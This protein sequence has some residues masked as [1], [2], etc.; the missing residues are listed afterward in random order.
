MNNALLFR[1]VVSVFFC[2]AGAVALG[3]SSGEAD[4]PPAD[5]SSSPLSGCEKGKIESDLVEGLELSGPGVDPQTKQV[6]AGS[7]VMAST[8]LAMRPGLD[9][10]EALGVAGPVVEAV[11]TAKGAV[12]VM[13]S[14]SADCAALRTLSV[15]ESEEDMFAFVMGPAHVEAMSHTSELSRG[16]SNTVS[17]EGTEEDV[18]WEE[19]ARRLASENA[20]DY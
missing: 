8:Y 17:W 13:A 4:D 15:W 6:R 20:S 5:G 14:Q 2:A 7:Y 3:C 10:G 18:T 12:A 11:M 16:T 1:G 9:H 19:G